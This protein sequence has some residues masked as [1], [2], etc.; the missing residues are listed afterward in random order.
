MLEN[1]RTICF[2]QIIKVKEEEK[3]CNAECQNISRKN[4]ETIKSTGTVTF[5][6]TMRF[7]YFLLTFTRS[8]RCL[9]SSFSMEEK[10]RLERRNLFVH[11]KFFD[12]FVSWK[13]PGTVSSINVILSL[14][15]VRHFKLKLY[16]P[17]ILPI[18]QI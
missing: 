9:R 18:S 2:L 3:R 1:D 11:Q 10:R 14:Y 15:L 17:I 4:R 13:K 7:R 16:N 6:T 8:P 5:Y 12:F